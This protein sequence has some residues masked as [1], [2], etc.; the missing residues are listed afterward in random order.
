MYFQNSSRNAHPSDASEY[1]WRDSRQRSGYGNSGSGSSETARNCSGVPLNKSGGGRGGGGGHGGG[2]P[3]SGGGDGG[4]GRDG[5]RGRGKSRS[6]ILMKLAA[7]DGSWSSIA[8]FVVY[9]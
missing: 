9:L 2:G 4:G 7:K 6:N 3:D 1:G 8:F 5:G